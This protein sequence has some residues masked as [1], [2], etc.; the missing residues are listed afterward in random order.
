MCLH[1]ACYIEN[2]LAGQ[3]VTIGVMGQAHPPVGSLVSQQSFEAL[4][5]YVHIGS[6]QLDCSGIHRF[7]ALC[8]VTHDQNGLTQ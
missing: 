8:C 3:S 2:P 1:L 5:D 4:A 7:R 6:H